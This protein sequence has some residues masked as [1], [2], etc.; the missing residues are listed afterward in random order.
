MVNLKE[1]V[2]STA[3]LLIPTKKLMKI[4]SVKGSKKKSCALVA[5]LFVNELFKHYRMSACVRM[6]IQIRC[7]WVIMFTHIDISEV[8]KGCHISCASIFTCM[9]FPRAVKCWCVYTCLH[10]KFLSM[11]RHSMWTKCSYT[12]SFWA[13]HHVIM[14]LFT[15]MCTVTY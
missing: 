1:T 11:V 5:K 4:T 10:M 7:F 3:T 9:H 8:S 2:Y 15:I 6:F 14:W 13:W 12:C